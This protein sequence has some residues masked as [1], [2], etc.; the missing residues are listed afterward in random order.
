MEKIERILHYPLVKLAEGTVSLASLLVALV[1]VLAA[2]RL[3]RL[4]RSA[5]LRVLMA[6]DV[7]PGTRFA[8]TRLL[9]YLIV[10]IGILVALNSMGIKLDALLTASAAL[11][12]G[13]GFGLQNIAQNFV[14]GLILLLEQ[15]IRPGDLV[16]IGGASGTVES[17]GLRATQ[18]VTRDQVAMIVPNSELVTSIVINHSR[19]VSPV[20]VWVRVGVAYGS[21]MARVRDALLRV[22]AEHPAVLGQPPPEV[23]LEDFGDSSLAFSLL[24]WVEDPLS[25]LRVSSDLRFAIDAVFREVGIDIPFPQRDLHLRSVVSS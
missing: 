1:V 15:P 8:V 5:L 10:A 9:G 11:L 24:F 7:A 19:P 20:R 17:I 14:A 13:I 12:V 16:R 4:T 22:A 2:V 25:D 3:A 21:D 18:I 6:R 23:R